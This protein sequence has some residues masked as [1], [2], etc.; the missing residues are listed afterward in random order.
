M[1]IRAVARRLGRRLDG[2]VGLPVLNG[3]YDRYFASASG[4]VRLFRGIYSDF[5]TARAS[6]PATKPIGY[7]NEASAL[8]LE[9]ERHKASP[10]D[11]PV[12]FWLQKLIRDDSVVFDY[13]GNVGTCFYNFQRYLAY[14]PRMRWIVCDVPAVAAAGAAI[15]RDEG[16]TQLSFTTDFE[17][18]EETDIFLA[19]G[20][21]QYIE[22]PVRSLREAAKRPRHVLVNRTS[23]RESETVVTLQSIGTS[24]CPYYLFNRK[25]FLS[26]FTDLGYRLVDEWKN[27]GLG[28]RIPAHSKYNLDQYSGFYFVLQ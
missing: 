26:K 11:Y 3:L 1:N 27:P 17:G 22:D 20:V 9:H 10:T 12:M 6:A 8:R 28:C 16:A 23:V 18:L 21:L 25:E 13:G 24:F 2:M 5:V 19:S 14:P 4:D 15:A 7:D